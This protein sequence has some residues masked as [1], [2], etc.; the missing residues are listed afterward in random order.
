MSLCCRPVMLSAGWALST[1]MSTSD[2]DYSIDWLASD[3][4]DALG[5]LGGRDPRLTEELWVPPSTSSLRG[6]PT[7]CCCCRATQWRRRQGGVTADSTQQTSPTSPVQG[8]NS[9]YAQPLV[10]PRRRLSR[11]RANSGGL[12][13]LCEKAA[14]HSEDQLFSQKVRSLFG[15]NLYAFL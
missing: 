10:E 12:D 2:S 14:G 13:G 3:D 8:F 9:I 15:L 7:S 1:T 11:K 5:S 4:D 6:S